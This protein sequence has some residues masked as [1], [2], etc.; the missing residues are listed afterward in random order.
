MKNF[1]IFNNNQITI[2]FDNL[3]KILFIGAS[4]S[5][6]RVYEWKNSFFQFI[7]EWKAHEP[8]VFSVISTSIYPYLISA[9]RDASIRVWNKENFELIHEIP[10][11]IQTINH[12]QLS[13][14]Q[15]FMLS[16]SMDKLIKLWDIKNDFRLIK[17]IDKNR[18]DSHS[19]SVN[20][21]L[22]LDYN[23]SV[24]TCS[25]DRKIIQWAID[26]NPQEKE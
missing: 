22:W 26:I 18:N 10:A 6:I 3:T 5:K 20:Q 7:K 11:H 13:P 1:F 8:S 15:D 24:I 25:D 4:D 9:G 21:M 2:N 12:L 14:N 23:D 16:S 17:V 19:A